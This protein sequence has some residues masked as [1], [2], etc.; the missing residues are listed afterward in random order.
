LS[1]SASA[2]PLGLVRPDYDY[3][4]CHLQFWL[5]RLVMLGLIVLMLFHW[6]HRFR[7]TL[8]DGFNLRSWRLRSPCCATAVRWL[9][10][11]PALLMC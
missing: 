3:S 4:A 1:Y 2:I 6:A 10:R 5:T 11:L 8:H 9:V 7:Y